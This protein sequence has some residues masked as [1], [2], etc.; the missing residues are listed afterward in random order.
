MF[1]CYLLIYMVQ[2]FIYCV[3]T[4][5]LLLQVVTELVVSAEDEASRRTE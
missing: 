1:E 4:C 5:I 2:V 3:Y